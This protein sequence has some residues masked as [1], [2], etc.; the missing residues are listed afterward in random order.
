MHYDCMVL[1]AGIVGVSTALQLQAR[2]KRVCLIDQLAP[3][4]GTSFGNAGLIERSSV[5]PYSFPRH[6]STLVKY[7]LNQQ[8]DVRYDLSF[9]PKIMPWLAKYWWQSETNRLASAAQDMWPLIQRSVAEHDHWIEQAELSHL[10]RAKG[11]IEVFRDEKSFAH[12]QRELS[13]LSQYQLNYDVLNAQQL[14]KREPHLK[15]GIKG[16]IHWLDPK[17]VTDPSEIVKG[18]ARLFNHLG[19]VFLKANA[20]T[21]HKVGRF[22]Q[23]QAIDQAIEADH[24]VIALG[25]DSAEL[26]KQFNCIVPLAVKRGYHKHYKM[27]EANLL[28]HSLCDHLAGFILA[29][30]TKGI[31]LTTGIEFANPHKRA[32]DIQLSR[33]E[34]VARVI[35]PLGEAIETT[36]WLGR[37]PCISDMRPIIGAVPHAAGLWANF[38]H[39]HH[40]LT[41]GPISGRLLADLITNQEPFTDP[42]PYR[43]ERFR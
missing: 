17:T 39:A 24:A 15:E 31:R 16:G 27:D 41:L 22:W 5:I 29:P 8:T 20:R 26:L 12:A 33:A 36:P 13:A 3:G 14:I 42:S 34:K 7:A 19:G 30:M 32:M 35:F 4:E 18:Y 10:L 6:F 25:F 37:R 11:W 21:L 43:L 23:V 38:G 1:G 2:G 28:E 9:L 40:G